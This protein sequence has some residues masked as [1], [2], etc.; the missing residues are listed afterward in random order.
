VIS[1]MLRVGRRAIV[2]FPN[3]GYYKL[4]WE[5]AEHGRAPLVEL[6]GGS[7][8]YD[9]LNVRFLTLA[10]FDEF[11]REQG[12]TIHKHVCL[13]TETNRRITDDPNRNADLAIVVISR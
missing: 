5:L 10:D 6:G 4:R 13:D 1:E 9:T 3:L 7:R 2:S 11:C 8:W 12:I